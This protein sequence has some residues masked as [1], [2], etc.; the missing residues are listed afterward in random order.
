MYNLFLFFIL[1]FIFSFKEIKSQTLLKKENN[2][3]LQR[4]ENINNFLIEETQIRENNKET[5]IRENN[6]E[7]QI[8]ENNKETQIRENNK[9]TQL[10]ENNKET[11]LRENDKEF[12]LKENKELYWFLIPSELQIDNLKYKIKLKKILDNKTFDVKE[13]NELIEIYTLKNDVLVKFTQNQKKN[14]E[15][16]FCNNIN[17]KNKN[18]FKKN[19]LEISKRQYNLWK[20]IQVNYRLSIL[21]FLDNQRKLTKNKSDKNINLNDLNYYKIVLEQFKILNNIQLD[22]QNEM[23][24]AWQSYIFDLNKNCETNLS[25]NSDIKKSKIYDFSKIDLR[26]YSIALY[27]FL[28]FLNFNQR[29]EFVKKFY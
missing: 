27:R 25:K 28:K 22:L 15:E 20:K 24:V 26:T 3:E 11:Q 19:L 13:L 2:E 6:K 5:Q 29:Q 8:R 16:K 12:N 10:K 17:S 4:E 18:T 9:E 21:N 23:S 1:S 14:I 7:T